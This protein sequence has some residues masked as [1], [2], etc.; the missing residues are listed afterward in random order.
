MTWDEL[1][2][3][4]LVSAHENWFAVAME[5]FQALPAPVGG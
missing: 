5:A 1:D 4:S 3:A 2:F